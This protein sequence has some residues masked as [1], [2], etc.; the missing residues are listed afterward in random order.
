[1]VITDA[2]SGQDLVIADSQLSEPQFLRLVA[3][4]LS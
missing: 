2:A 1:V 3:T 4:G